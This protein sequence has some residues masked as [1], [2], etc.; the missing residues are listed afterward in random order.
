MGEVQGW[1]H[2][3]L[4]FFYVQRRGFTII[5]H[6]QYTHSQ[7]FIKHIQVLKLKTKPY[8]KSNSRSSEFL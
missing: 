3:V 2:S 1:D 8:E 4:P 6:T 7:T 5:I